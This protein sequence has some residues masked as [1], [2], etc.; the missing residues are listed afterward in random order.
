MA[1]RSIRVRCDALDVIAGGARAAQV[2]DHLLLA[3]LAPVRGMYVR[4]CYAAGLAQRQ[5]VT[6]RDL[7]LFLGVWCGGERVL[8][9]RVLVW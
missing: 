8:V 7:G 1:H 3:E 2:G 6:T 4:L 9:V 5:E